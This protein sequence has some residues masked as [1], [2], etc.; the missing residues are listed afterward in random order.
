MEEER[1]TDESLDALTKSYPIEDVFKG[2]IGF[3]KGHVTGYHAGGFFRNS[4]AG[5]SEAE[6]MLGSIAKNVACEGKWFGLVVDN[7][8]P[9]DAEAK[10]Y[11]RH[12][13]SIIETGL[14]ELKVVDDKV[15]LKPTEKFAELAEERDRML[16]PT[17]I[18]LYAVENDIETKLFVAANDEN[19]LYPKDK[20]NPRILV[21]AEKGVTKGVIEPGREVYVEG[22]T[23]S[24]KNYRV[25]GWVEITEK[26][27][28]DIIDFG[29][30][31]KLLDALLV[32]GKSVK[33]L[34]EKRDMPKIQESRDKFE[35]QLKRLTH[36]SYRKIGKRGEEDIFFQDPDVD[37]KEMGYVGPYGEFMWQGTVK[38]KE[39]TAYSVEILIELGDE[40]KELIVIPKREEKKSFSGLNR[41]MEELGFGE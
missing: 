38:D 37:V 39:G 23:N 9:A 15:Y 32:H 11:G 7:I 1:Y 2:S 41:K 20:N 35:S 13:A 33:G 14:A 40:L 21:D 28:N 17:Y 29:R 19:H 4:P 34:D 16:F 27:L 25:E 10:Q 30:E 36:T 26:N 12:L 3:W 5:S 18:R 31:N 6:L 8:S 24:D 22:E